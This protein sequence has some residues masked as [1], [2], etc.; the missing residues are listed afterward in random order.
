MTKFGSATSLCWQPANNLIGE[1]L[2]VKSR[3]FP[4]FMKKHLFRTATMARPTRPSLSTIKFESNQAKGP[5]PSART[6][7]LEIQRDEGNIL[8]FKTPGLMAPSSRGV[9][10][11]LSQDQLSRVPDLGWIHAP[12]EN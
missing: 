1:T 3:G 6:G 9:V 4:I 7:T 5:K 10:P 12:F 11:H 8:V 2:A